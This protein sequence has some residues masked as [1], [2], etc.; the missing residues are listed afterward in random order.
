MQFRTFSVDSIP[1][2]LVQIVSQARWSSPQAKEQYKLRGKYEKSSSMSEPQTFFDCVCVCQL[3][4]NDVGCIQ[5]LFKVIKQ[6]PKHLGMVNFVHRFQ[7]FYQLKHVQCME[8]EKYF[9]S[10]DPLVRARQ[11]LVL[12]NHKIQHNKDNN[13]IYDTVRYYSITEL[14]MGDSFRTTLHTFKYIY[15]FSTTTIVF[16]TLGG[17]KDFCI[18]ASLSFMSGSVERKN[19][20]SSL[21]IRVHSGWG[22][23]NIKHKTE[24]CVKQTILPCGKGKQ[25]SKR[26]LHN[27][28][29]PSLPP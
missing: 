13:R 24:H 29:N 16:S 4:D 12:F 7:N 10:Y 5:T 22:M 11:Q 3:G 28:Q 21:P 2:L 17:D 26:V 23:R 6:T 9:F 15:L 14:C 27:I 25:K 20:S 18:K 8:Y 19:S 1:T